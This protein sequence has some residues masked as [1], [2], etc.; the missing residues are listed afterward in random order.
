MTYEDALEDRLIYGTPDSV[1]SRLTEWRDRLGLSV[2]IMEPNVGGLISPDL[3]SNS[4]RL[5]GQEVA[6]KT[7]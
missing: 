2:V 6:P 7:Q 5:F 1:A 3:L 4:I